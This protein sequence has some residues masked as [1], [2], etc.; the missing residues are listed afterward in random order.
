MRRWV[1]AAVGLALAAGGAAG[2]AVFTPAGVS[3]GTPAS[4]SATTCQ[5]DGKVYSRG[6]VTRMSDNTLYVCSASDNGA[7][8]WEVARDA[9]K[10]RNASS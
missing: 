2:Y 7:A 9:A 8:S 3:A 10:R 4:G 6:S 5:H 1:M